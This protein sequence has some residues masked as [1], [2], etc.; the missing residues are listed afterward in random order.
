MLASSERVIGG[1]LGRSLIEPEFLDGMS[2]KRNNK[3]N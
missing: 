1:A 3:S 2:W